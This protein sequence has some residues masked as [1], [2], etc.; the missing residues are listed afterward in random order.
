MGFLPDVSLHRAVIAMAI[1]HMKIGKFMTAKI[2]WSRHAD[3]L[4]KAMQSEPN[5]AKRAELHARYEELMAMPSPHFYAD[6][7]AKHGPVGMERG[8]FGTKGL[9]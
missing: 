3:A 2:A 5:E 8:P 9:W 4:L 7:L 6:W 1:D